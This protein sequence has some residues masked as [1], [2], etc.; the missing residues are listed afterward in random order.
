[1]K[2]AGLFVSAQDEA[3]LATLRARLA[4][5][6]VLPFMNVGSEDRTTRK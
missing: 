4:S 6:G 2:Q 3:E 5:N 1:M